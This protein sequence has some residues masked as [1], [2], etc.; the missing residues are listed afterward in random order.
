ME[1]IIK[2]SS[3]G[4][5]FKWAVIYLVTSIVLI[6]LFQFLDIDQSSPSRYIT[7]LPYIAF[8]FLAQKEYRDIKGGY[9]SFGDGFL[10]GLFFAIFSGI[11]SSIFTYLYF[12]FIY[13]HAY[14]E[15][16]SAMQAKFVA[17]GMSDGQIDSQM[18]I[19]KNHGV[20]ITAI[21]GL[22]GAPVIGAIISLIGAAIFKRE[23][24]PLDMDSYVDP[25]V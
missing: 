24:S 9:M 19:W 2:K 25:T 16:L 10:A 14:E 13:P 8:L 1:T 17:A 22:I 6:F 15:I 20:L 3:T 5:A 11:M 23:R 21:G 4:I 7:F 12:N 18:S